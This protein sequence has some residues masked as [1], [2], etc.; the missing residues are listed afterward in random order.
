MPASARTSGWRSCG[1]G[2]RKSDDDNRAGRAGELFEALL[3]QPWTAAFEDE[4][5]ALLDKAADG[6]DDAA[7]RLRQQVY[8]LHRWIDR[9]EEARNELYEREIKEPEK[10][11]RTELIEK[12]KE[13]QKRARTEL[14]DKLAA[15]AKAR[16]DGLKPLAARRAAAPGD[17][18]GA[19]AGESRR[20]VLRAARSAAAGGQARR[21][22]A[23]AGRAAGPA[24][25]GPAAD[26]AH[27]SLATKR[28]TQAAVTP[29]LEKY[30]DALIAQDAD[31]TQIGLDGR[32]G[33]VRAARGA[34][35]AAGIAGGCL[36]PGRS[37]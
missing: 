6:G 5:F 37:R 32:T 7:L 13:N 3:E 8:Y 29:R 14:A 26:D 25:P 21:G 24:V 33:E 28:E 10:L 30:V 12:R 16:Q 31:G 4:S 2:W 19:R 9:M 36:P 23:D 18:A 1:C 34:G 35:P 15:A 27:V 17:Q 22:R 20:V 11:K